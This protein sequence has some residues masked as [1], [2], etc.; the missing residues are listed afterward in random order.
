MIRQIVGRFLE[1]TRI[2]AF[3]SSADLIYLSSADMMTR[4][5]EH[6]VE[7]AYPVLDELCRKLVVQF[8]NIQ[9]ADNVKAR[10]LKSDGRYVY[11]KRKKGEPKLRSQEWF[12]EHKGAWHV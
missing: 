12:I 11:R 1:H 6:R 8:V 7:I 9:L 2:Y 5:T 4:N 3:G 10:E